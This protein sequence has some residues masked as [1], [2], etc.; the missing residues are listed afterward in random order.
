MSA[1]ECHTRSQIDERKEGDEIMENESPKALAAWGLQ[2]KPY[3]NAG[4]RSQH[5][6]MQKYKKNG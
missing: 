6:M 3:H 1:L 2:P 4:I 5:I